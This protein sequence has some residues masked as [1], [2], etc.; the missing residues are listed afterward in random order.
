MDTIW[1][2]VI[3]ILFALLYLFV[4]SIA[5]WFVLYVIKFLEDLK[6]DIEVN[7]TVNGENNHDGENTP[8]DKE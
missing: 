1:M 2:V 6:G 7:I 8:S 4:V 3:G 5:I